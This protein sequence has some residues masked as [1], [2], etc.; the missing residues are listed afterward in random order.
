MRITHHKNGV[1]IYFKDDKMIEQGT[2]EWHQLRAGKVTASRVADILAKTKTGPSA[3]RQN[4]LIQLALER[5]T[6]Q[7]EESFTSSA[8]QDGIDRESQ[9]RTL[10]EITTGTFVSQVA[11]RNHHVIENF[12]CSPDGEVDDEPGLIE[13]K[14]RGNAGHWEVIKSKEIPKKYWI[15]QQA[16][17]SCTG[18]DWND[19]VG[20]NPNFPDKSKLYIQRVYRDDK[21]ILEMESEI[22]QFLDEVAEETER[23]KNGG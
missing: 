14:C 22:K 4:Y 18:M 6:G 9:A 5:V 11:F 21:F 10:Y 17:L 1:I 3:S 13:I 8:M 16:Q 23:I 12:G 2:P 7:I 15:Q 20:Y 19:Y